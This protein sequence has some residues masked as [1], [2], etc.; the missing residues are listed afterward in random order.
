MS[1]YVHDQLFTC[2]FMCLDVWPR[3]C[4]LNFNQGVKID[5][6]N[7]NNN[8]RNNKDDDDNNNNNIN[9][10]SIKMSRIDIIFFL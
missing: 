5:K 8:N 3:A 2:M 6:V 9:N 4:P 1:Q 7:N 10:N